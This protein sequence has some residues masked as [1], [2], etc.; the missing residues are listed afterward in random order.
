MANETYTDATPAADSAADY[1]SITADQSAVTSDAFVEHAT[2]NDG[3][4]LSEDTHLRDQETVA[5][6][7]LAV[8]ARQAQLDLVTNV[9][10]TNATDSSV[11][12]ANQILASEQNKENSDKQL[13]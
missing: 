12:S 9:Y 10:G 1:A 6:D 7:D 3:A 11:V 5:F 8:Q 2:P 13:P 4:L